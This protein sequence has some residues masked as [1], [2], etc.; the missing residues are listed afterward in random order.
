MDNS[1]AMGQA[2][3][4]NKSSSGCAYHMGT[5]RRITQIAF[6]LVVYLMPVL[7]IFRYDSS[8]KELIVF[9]Q[10]W[11]LGLKQ[12]FY[13]DHSLSGATHVAL[14]FFLK[15]ILP[16]VLVLSVFP[17]LGFLTGRSF[18]GWLCP[19]GALFEWADFLTVKLL[20][21]RNLYG[22]REND[23]D[24]GN[25]NKPFWLFITVVSIIFIPLCGGIAL[26]GYFAAPKTVWY[27]VT[28]GEFTFGVKA[29]IIGV[30]LY[31]LIGSRC[32][33]HTFCK[34][35]CAVGLMQMLFGW[36]SSVSLRLKV[37]TARIGECTDCK[38]CEKACF[39]N[40]LPRRNKRDVSCVNC[41]ACIDACNSELGERGLFHY[42]SGNAVCLTPA[43]N[44]TPVAKVLS[45]AKQL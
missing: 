37:D 35:V 3:S 34:Y 5:Y 6:I 7:N 15:A 43:E 26:T 41:G 24:A 23:P 33:R 16:W 8:A 25:F 4:C 32:V 45:R 22:K 20:G 19:E 31:M 27:Q 36:V 10:V 2:I 39:M 17:L 11:S 40:V 42:S 13:A 9:G 18:C 1:S 28:P 21:R 12:G 14:H 29:G 44:C 30:A 38:N